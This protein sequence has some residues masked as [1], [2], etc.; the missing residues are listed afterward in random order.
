MPT[1]RE[2]VQWSLMSMVLVISRLCDPS[3]E[4]HIA[5]HFYEHT[6]LSDLLGI[7]AEKINDED[8]L[9]KIE[10]SCRKRKYKPVTIAK[11]LGKLLGRNSRSAGLFET[12]VI[13]GG[14]GRAKLVWSKTQAWRNWADL[15]EG[16]YLLRSNLNDWDARELWKAYIQLTEAEAAFRIHKSD[17]KIRPI[18]H[19]KAERVEA[20]ILVCFLACVLWKTLGQMCSRGGLGDEPRRVLAEIARIK[21]VDV[22]LPTKPGW[23]IRRRCVSRPTDHQAILLQRLGLRLPTNLPLT[24]KKLKAM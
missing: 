5:E 1:G 8:G 10:D 19:Q 16:C 22:V 6:A 3:S 7:P 11:R 9:R 21:A 2:D 17:L 4:L 18:W 15:S 24:D 20:H 14:D 12:D 13:V 23:E